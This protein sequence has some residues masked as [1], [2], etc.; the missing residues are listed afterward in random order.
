[1]TDA[2][3]L[4]VA[5][6]ALQGVGITVVVGGSVGIDVGA[7]VGVN[8]GERVGIDVGAAVDV[9]G[10]LIVGEVVGAMVGGSH[11]TYAG[12]VKSSISALESPLMASAAYEARM[13][14][15]DKSMPNTALSAFRAL[16]YSLIAASSLTATAMSAP[17]ERPSTYV[18]S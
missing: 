18:A 8:V 7:G 5:V 12:F 1:M 6:K 16:E 3:Q 15:P 10:R 4:P 14:S 17:L 9:G 13:P 2:E 11:A